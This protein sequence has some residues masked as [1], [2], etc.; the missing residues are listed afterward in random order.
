MAFAQGGVFESETCKFNLL[1]ARF[2][3]VE[4]AEHPFIQRSIVFKLQ[5]A[6]RVRDALDRIGE[7]MGK[8][9]HRIDTPGVPSA[10]MRHVANAVERGVPHGDIG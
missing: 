2:W 1:R 9:V 7:A 10:I 5:G 4:G 8:V 3:Q 6:Q